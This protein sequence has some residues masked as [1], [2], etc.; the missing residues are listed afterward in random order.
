[1]WAMIRRRPLRFILLGALLLRWASAGVLQDHLDQ[2]PNRDFLIEGDAGGYWELGRRIASGEDYE[3]HQPPRQVLRMPG[4]PAVLAFS[5]KMV[6]WM[7][8]HDLRFLAAR[9]LLAGVGTLG[10]GL[11]YW[12]GKELFDETTGLI[13]AGLTAVMPTMVIFS[14]VILSET[15]FAAALLASLLAMSKLAKTDLNPFCLWRSI[16]L[17]LAAGAMVALACYVRPS[18][19]LAAPLFALLNLWIAENK[20]EAVLRGG[21]VM[22]GLCLAL[23]PWAFRNYRVTGHWV[24][25]TLWVGPSLY[26]GLNP[27]ATGDSN[28]QFFEE[29]KLMDKM[30][31]YEVDQVYRQKARQFA[32]SNPGRTIQLA[33]IK[34]W[35][36]WKPWP[37]AAQFG[38]G[39]TKLAVGL[40]FVPLVLL[41]GRG[42]W[43]CRAQP[44]S[45]LLTLGPILYFS[46]LHMVFVASL[47]YRLPAEYPLCLLSAAGLRSFWQAKFDCSSQAG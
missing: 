37:N 45:W 33:F 6:E 21:L 3:I 16:C 24:V 7:G 30:S 18:W 38:G 14:V 17:P 9:M 43:T 40:F 20:K 15:L 5:M 39:W 2:S 1:M 32:F 25:T 28:M 12:L 41:A 13:A 42:W 26:D 34:L 46:I 31:E 4:F 27:K 11:V 23:A 22:A 19:L 47:R 35:R 8:G 29:D 10:C 44:W 36:F